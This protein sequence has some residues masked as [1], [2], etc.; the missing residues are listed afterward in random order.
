M[1]L[2]IVHPICGWTSVVSPSCVMTENPSIFSSHSSDLRCICTRP[3]PLSSCGQGPLREPSNCAYD[4]T[5]RTS[6]QPRTLPQIQS[7]TLVSELSISDGVSPEHVKQRNLAA[8]LL[9][10]ALI[11]PSVASL[12]G[13][14]TS[15]FA[16]VVALPCTSQA[17]PLTPSTPNTTRQFDT[18]SDLLLS[19]PTCT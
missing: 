16:Q 14:H 1:P 17:F 11:H 13:R 6:V 8:P 2:L 4:F 5:Y 19:P 7:L 12:S 18:L 3:R 15:Q 9:L 10:A